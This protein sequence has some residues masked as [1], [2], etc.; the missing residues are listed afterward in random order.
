M[1][2]SYALQMSYDVFPYSF[3]TSKHSQ[4]NT[5][6]LY[7]SYGCLTGAFQTISNHVL[8]QSHSRMYVFHRLLY[9]IDCFLS[10]P[11]PPPL[12]NIKSPLIVLFLVSF[13]A[14]A[15]LQTYV[16]NRL[17]NI[18]RRVA[19]MEQDVDEKFDD[20]TQRDVFVYLICRLIKII[21]NSI[22]MLLL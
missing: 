1:R 15:L 13:I 18:S 9:H 12:S 16:V 17:L 8:L 5:I 4:Y 11:T 21:T 14:Y 7:G 3:F 2:H 20:R 22:I 10:Y 19:P 6:I